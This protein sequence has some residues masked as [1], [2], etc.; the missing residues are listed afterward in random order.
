MVVVGVLI[1]EKHR[2]FV[3]TATHIQRER[4]RERERERLT[5]IQRQTYRETNAHKI[6]V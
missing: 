6:Y 4:E 1:V 3:C 2:H 5:M